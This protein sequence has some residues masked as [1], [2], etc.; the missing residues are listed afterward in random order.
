MGADGSIPNPS[1]DEATAAIFPAHTEDVPAPPPDELNAHAW[2]MVAEDA[3]GGPE[4]PVH[5]DWSKG[6]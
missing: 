4:M 1:K 5:V 6:G 2:E 3:K